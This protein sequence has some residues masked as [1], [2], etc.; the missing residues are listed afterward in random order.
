M[1][2]PSF[3][4]VMTMHVNGGSKYSELHYRIYSDGEPTAITRHKR[5]G[6][7]PRYLIEMDVFR[8]GEAEFDNLAARG[9]G[10]M[11]WVTAQHAAT[12]AAKEATP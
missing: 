3:A 6:G 7:R 10:L 12:K 1:N 5:T 2:K 8:C 4:Q 11:E 9:R